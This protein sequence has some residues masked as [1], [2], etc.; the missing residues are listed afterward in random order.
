MKTKESRIK[1]LNQRFENLIS[2]GWQKT[3]YKDVVFFTSQ[4]SGKYFLNVFIGTSTKQVNK[5]YYRSEE[6][7]ETAINDY[8]K[9]ADYR[10]E[11][12]KQPK[13][14]SN[15]A[16][17][18]AAIRKE[19]KEIFP[20]VKFSVK[21]EGYSMGDSVHVNYTDGPTEKEVNEII[22][23]YQYGHFNGMEDIYEYSNR[24]EDIPQSKYVGCSRSISDEVENIILP[25]ITEIYNN[26]DA[27]KYEGNERNLL[28]RLM[29]KTSIP[30]NAKILGIEKTDCRCGNFADFYKVVFSEPQ[31]TVKNEDE[32]IDFRKELL[33][34]NTPATTDF[35]IIKT[36][37]TLKNFDLWVVKMLERV[38]KNTFNSFLATCKELGGWY[39][40]FAKNGA[41]NGF[42]FKTEE[43]ANKFL[44]AVSGNVQRTKEPTQ[45][46]EVKNNDSKNSLLAEKWEKLAEG[47]KKE[48]D[49]K[50]KELEHAPSHTPKQ[51]RQY[52]Q[53]RVDAEIL[54]D[55]SI[56]AYGLANAYKNNTIPDELKVLQPIK[57]AGHLMA[58]LPGH[59]SNGYYDAH[60]ARE[61]RFIKI[62]SDYPKID[63]I[64]SHEQAVKILE[65]LK[66]LNSIS[67]E[68]QEQREKENRIKQLE[69]NFKFQK[70]AGFFPTP[71]DLVEKMIDNLKITNGQTI[72]EPSAGLGHIAE[73]VKNTF[74]ENKLHTVE[75]NSSL[76]E[77]LT[78]KGFE[79]TN[80]DFLEFNEKFDRIIMN[81]PFEK[82][83]D[84][85]HVKHAFDLLNEGGRIVSIMGAGAFNNST[86]KHID[87]QTWVDKIGA[88]YYKLPDQ[89]FK[90][91]FKSTNVA[92]YLVI[93]DK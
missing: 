11:R 24:R 66:E 67:P 89:S 6:R 45:K 93:I 28:Y 56:F 74:P 55:A 88:E 65:L 32:Y 40:S 85:D 82:A 75:Y 15:Q 46:T 50:Y 90:D 34:E 72:L 77:I 18:A 81:P 64:N 3:T 19:L 78:L 86:K 62:E 2:L 4:E 43:S 92:T 12:K 59:A 14:Q 87:F 16:E 33:G 21:S 8:K 42:Q 13:K 20:N 52:N 79:T 80:K 83:Q 76:A 1:E 29:K 41:V 84:I 91:A 57:S 10:D 47:Y 38:D 17:A 44:N 51:N 54:E 53:K 39:S 68:K 22:D 9:T 70:I 60:R 37:H 7:R 36:V 48:S 58:F 61:P 31:K 26:S 63:G 25:F 73:V 71:S 30:T 69:D 35:E 23:K 49:K 5:Y 27:W